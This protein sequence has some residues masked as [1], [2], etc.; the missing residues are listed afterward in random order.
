MRSKVPHFGNH[1]FDGCKAELSKERAKDNDYNTRVHFLWCATSQL[2][3]GGSP[4]K[5]STPN[6]AET[7]SDSGKYSV[8]TL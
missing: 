2:Y 4:I 1:K 3:S 6:D 5:T 7:D 8:P